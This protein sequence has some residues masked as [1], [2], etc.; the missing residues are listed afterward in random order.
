MKRAFS[1]TE[2]YR[3]LEIYLGSSSGEKRKRWAR[4]IIERNVDIKDLCKLL[5]GDQKIAIRFLWLLTEIGIFHPKILLAELPFLLATCEPLHPFHQKSFV[6]FWLIAGVPMENEGKAI[7]LL[8]EWLLSAHTNVTT[9][10]R[11]MLVLFT[12][13]NKYPELKNELTL[14]L[15]EVKDKYTKDFAKRTNKL[16]QKLETS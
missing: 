4:A 8:F 13:S 14:C 16:L 11:S 3:E 2:F 6:S 15:K 5:N 10:S 1:T 7:S 9:K 12:L